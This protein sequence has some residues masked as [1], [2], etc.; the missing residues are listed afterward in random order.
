MANFDLNSYETVEQ[1]HARAIEA[2]PDLRCEIINHTTAE[3]RANKT[4][5]VE[6]RVYLNAADQSLGLFKASDWAFE[7]DGAG[8]ANK[9]SALENA[10][11]SALGRCLRWA[12]AG[13][14]GPSREE[15]EKVE[16]VAQQ[17]TGDWLSK[18]DKLTDVE[19]LRQ[20]WAQAKAGNADTEI[21]DRIK[22]RANQ[23]ASSSSVSGGAEGSVSKLLGA[24]VQ[25][26]AT[27]PTGS[28]KNGSKG[29]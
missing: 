26:E 10:S 15:M 12:L 3:D 27:G 5:V 14:R 9:T 23:L 29:V 19:A 28:R 11:T 22:A 18:A 6:A 2:Y 7:I 8:M 21:L 20:L 16:R 25:S 24:D 1:R 4:W 13:S 17:A